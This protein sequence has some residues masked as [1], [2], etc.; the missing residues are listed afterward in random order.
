MLIVL[1][2]GVKVMLVSAKEHVSQRD[3]LARSVLGSTVILAQAGSALKGAKCARIAMEKSQ[4]MRSAD[5]MEIVKVIGAKEAMPCVVDD[6]SPRKM[7]VRSAMKETT[8]L[9][10][11]ESAGVVT[12]VPIRKV[13][14]LMA[15]TVGQTV[16]V[17]IGLTAWVA[18]HILG[19]VH[20]GHA[21]RRPGMGRRPQGDILRVSV[22]TKNVMSAGVGTL[23]QKVGSVQKMGTAKAISVQAVGG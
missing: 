6:A 10:K 11:V 7:M 3:C 5:I 18:V 9:A 22:G 14:C 13:G 19:V 1:Q 4:T 2:A 20:Q 23:F 21:P 8:T 12:T 17:D 15:T 16:T